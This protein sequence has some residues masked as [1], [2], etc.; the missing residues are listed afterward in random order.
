M[1]EQ[2]NATYV[3]IMT[4]EVLGKLIEVHT[5]SVLGVDLTT[6]SVVAEINNSF[7]VMMSIPDYDDM[8]EDSLK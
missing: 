3:D 6:N 8:F 1:E 7:I 2:L 4:I 5:S